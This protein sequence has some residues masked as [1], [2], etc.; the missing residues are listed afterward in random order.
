MYLCS[1][2]YPRL[3]IISL[4]DMVLN[5]DSLYAAFAKDSVQFGAEFWDSGGDYDVCK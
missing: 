2:F 1:T 4:G 3:H 5:L